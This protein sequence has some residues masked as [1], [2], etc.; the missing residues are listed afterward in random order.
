MKKIISLLFILYITA[1]LFAYDS[2]SLCYINPPKDGDIKEIECTYYINHSE[3]DISNVLLENNIKSHKIKR[4]LQSL[5]NCPW[6]GAGLNL[7]K[8]TPKQITWI[9]DDL[10]AQY[11]DGEIF[12]Y[13]CYVTFTYKNNKKKTS[14]YE[15]AVLSNVQHIYRMADIK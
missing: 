11:K 10:I 4:V 3:E 13:L 12:G 7:G 5:N 9:N 2:K 6:K 8:G 14:I 15:Y 1:F